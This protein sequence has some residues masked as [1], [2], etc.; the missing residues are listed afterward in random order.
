MKEDTS[1]KYSRIAKLYDLFEWPIEKLLFKKTPKRISV[2]CLR[3]CTG[4]RYRHWQE[5]TLLQ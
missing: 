3:S 2:I 4:S 5:L 1:H